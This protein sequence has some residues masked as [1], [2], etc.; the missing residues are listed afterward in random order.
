MEIQCVVTGKVQAVGF[1]DYA[2]N[3]AAELDLKGYIKNNPDGSVFVLAQGEPESLRLYVEHLHEGSI[4]AR[5]DGVA[6]EWRTSSTT[7]DDFSIA[8]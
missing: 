8:R 3:A 4:L 1:R 5:V 2:Q 6:V 7:F